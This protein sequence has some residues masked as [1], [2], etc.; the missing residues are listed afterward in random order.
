MTFAGWTAHLPSSPL[1][2]S[3]EEEDEKDDE[4]DDDALLVDLKPK[5]LAPRRD[6]PLKW[7]SKC[8]L[9]LACR[10]SSCQG[11]GHNCRHDHD[12]NDSTTA[13]FLKLNDQKVSTV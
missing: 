11:T 4:E 9:G 3:E 10:S 7:K 1:V 12:H 6:M 2:D 8:H 13:T 5:Q